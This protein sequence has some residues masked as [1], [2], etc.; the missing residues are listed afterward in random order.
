[1]YFQWCTIY[2]TPT[3]LRIQNLLFS[4][5]VLRRTI[6]CEDDKV[7]NLKRAPVP[8]SYYVGLV[9]QEAAV[10][11]SVASIQFSK[12]Q[13]TIVSIKKRTKSGNDSL[14]ESHVLSYMKSNLKP[15]YTL[16]MASELFEHFF[17]SLSLFKNISLWMLPQLPGGREN[18]AENGWTL[19]SLLSWPFISVY[20]TSP[21]PPWKSPIDF[22]Q[23]IILMNISWAMCYVHSGN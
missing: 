22:D 9:I 7:N 17:F 8:W 2:C 23:I 19:G 3:S 18:G 16:L 10:R 1:M 15:T 14:C 12:H 13:K 5:S 21:S 11:V 4:V 6:L 20:F